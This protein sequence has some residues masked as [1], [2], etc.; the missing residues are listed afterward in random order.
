MPM[1]IFKKIIYGDMSKLTT[2]FSWQHILALLLTFTV[3]VTAAVLLRKFPH[4]KI[5]RLLL[6][7]GIFFIVLEVF[8][9]TADSL[10]KGRFEK[11][12]IPLYSCSIFM[13]A[14][15]ISA[16][17]KNKR[18]QNAG[19]AFLATGLASGLL[20]ICAPAA[21]NYYPMG[22]FMIFHTFFYHGAMLFTALFL[23]TTGYYRLEIKHLPG[24]SI[25]VGSISVISYIVNIW[26]D[27][28]TMYTRNPVFPMKIIADI[29]GMTLYPFVVVIAQIVVI[30]FAAYIIYFFIGRITG[31]LARRNKL[32]ANSKLQIK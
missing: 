5:R 30:F 23:Y 19:N 3:A 8:K 17:A 15:L 32:L 25:L 22:S 13:Y 11:E 9:A 6:I 28:N 16:L 27:I 24:F 20:A 21:F 1:E 29:F 2:I 7:F 4:A 10:I 12:N 26:L 31:L 18:V 14:L